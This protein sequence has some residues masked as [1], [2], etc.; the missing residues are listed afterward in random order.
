[1]VKQ[2]LAFIKKEFCHIFRDKRTMLILLG[3]PVVQILL[4]GFAITTEVQN[5]KVGI[6]SPSYDVWTNRLIQRIDASEYFDV[7]SM[8]ASQDEVNEAFRRGKVDMVVSFQHGFGDALERDEG[9]VQLVADATDPN[10]SVMRSAYMSGIL[11]SFREDL[12]KGENLSS[13][14]IDTQVKLLYNPQM[15][16]SYNFV[17]GVMGL[18]LMLI[19]AM[20]TSISIV[21]EK[22]TGTME[23]LLVSPMKPVFVILSKTVPYFVLSLVNLVTILCLAVWVLH[24][25]IAGNLLWIILVSLLYIFVSL[26]LGLLISSV[27]RTQVAAMLGAGMIL[28]LPTVLLSGLIF[29]I[30]S[31]PSLLQGISVLLPA[32]WYISL[33]RKLMI[34]GVPLFYAWKELA[35]LLCM[36][37]ALLLVS[38]KLFKNRLE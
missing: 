38:L 27:A 17:P 34:E 9:A 22:E 23:L 37:V 8:F 32:R 15:K 18:I 19:C 1:M 5:V 21:R 12:M 30:E 14:G 29:P 2:W 6:L 36:A 33:I 16:S 35:I 24:V 20:M 4:F 26:S 13:S 7:V 25:P 28:M 11:S 10:M 3:M 31:M